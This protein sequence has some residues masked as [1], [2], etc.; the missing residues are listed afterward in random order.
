MVIPETIDGYPV[1][2]IAKYAFYDNKQLT[3]ITV[4]ECVVNIGKNAFYDMNDDVK[5]IIAYGSAAYEYFKNFD[6]D[7][8]Y[9]NA[10]TIKM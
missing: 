1:T 4:P 8:V 9:T 2:S 7:I 10:K 5:L 6:G 3:S